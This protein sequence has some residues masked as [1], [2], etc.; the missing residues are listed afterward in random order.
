MGKSSKSPIEIWLQ[1]YN[2]QSAKAKI[3]AHGA[4]TDGCGHSIMCSDLERDWHM[5]RPFLAIL[6]HEY[7]L[8]FSEICF[9][10]IKD[11][12]K[13]S[14]AQHFIFIPQKVWGHL[15]ILVYENAHVNAKQ[16]LFIHTENLDNLVGKWSYP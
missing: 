1:T 11:G 3:Q 15:N 6:M 12:L 10:H 14:H 4:E 2:Y 8:I 5:Q 7:V 13:L 9:Q 16:A